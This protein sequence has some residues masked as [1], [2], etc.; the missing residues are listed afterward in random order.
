[1]GVAEG[2]ETALAVTRD[3]GIPCWSTI[4]ADGLKAFTPPAIVKRLRIFGDN[5]PKYGGQAAAYALAHRMSVRLDCVECSVEIPNQ[6]GTDRSEEHTS[7]LQSLMR[8]SYAV[9]C[10]KKKNKT[11]NNKETDNDTK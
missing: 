9:F 8:I 4:S 6:T 5:D 7:E 11:Y 1:M 10:L 3:F 2:I